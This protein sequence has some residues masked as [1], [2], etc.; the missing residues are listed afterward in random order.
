MSI[1]RNLLPRD[2]R[3]G[4]GDA[5]TEV[6]DPA[7]EPVQLT[8]LGGATPT[9]PGSKITNAAT[10]KFA[11]L[12]LDATTAVGPRTITADDAT[13]PHRASAMTP[14]GGTVITG[15]HAVTT[16]AS[17]PA[18][19]DAT[20]LIS[21]N[22]LAHVLEKMSPEQTVPVVV[23][24]TRARSVAEHVTPR[25]QRTTPSQSQKQPSRTLGAYR[26]IET[27]AQ[28]A[29]GIVYRAE[30]ARRQP[31]AIKA[32]QDAKRH[33]PAIVARFFGESLATSRV[34]HPN[35]V[36]FYD[37]GY[38]AQG[39]AFLVMELLRGE[40]LSQRLAR[41]RPLDIPLAVDIA[42]QIAMGLEAAHRQGVIHRDL[43]PDNIFLSIDPHDPDGVLVKLIDFGVAKV[44][45]QGP[46]QTLAGDLLGT[47]AYMA[48]E[49]GRSAA[50]SD[51]RSDIYSLGCIL[52]E[53][54][55]GVVPFPGN[56]VETLVAHQ[57]AE[58]PPARALNPRVP[59]ALDEVVDRLLARDPTQR[60]QSAA[61]VAEALTQIGSR[62]GVRTGSIRLATMPVDS[63]PLLSVLAS[64]PPLVLVLVAAGFLVAI[65]WLILLLR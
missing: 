54:L 17:T 9:T 29:M 60:P 34:T 44:E 16:L 52:F 25:Q 4:G 36:R 63:R 12:D 28:G 58:R 56:V 23:P 24:R 19:E 38:D 6:S 2:R 64:L 61:E 41:E 20:N 57:T 53:M 22:E 46:T 51:A 47:P 33:D 10:D 7:T 45:G 40:T 3:D 42:C 13:A 39:S 30:N 1:T 18:H 32:L 15:E 35:I 43:K 37:F 8:E 11:R 26:I 65:V 49:Q 62:L 55:C 21:Q 48:P 59:L 14:T 31:V 5:V 50:D 27:L